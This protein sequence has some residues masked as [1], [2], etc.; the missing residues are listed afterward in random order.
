MKPENLTKGNNPMKSKRLIFTLAVCAACIDWTRLTGTVKSVNLKDS[1]VTIENRDGDLLTIPVDYQVTMKEKHDELRG[2]R[3][4]H[5][6]EKITLTR[7]QAEK[8]VED[9][10][11]MAQPEPTQHG[12]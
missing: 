12:Q 2:L 6:D 8:P 11:G 4:L 5:L 1:T 9:F 3:T 7:I 10:S